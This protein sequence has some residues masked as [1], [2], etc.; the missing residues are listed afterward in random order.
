M[1]NEREKWDRVVKKLN[2]DTKAGKVSWSID[3]AHSIK[4]QDLDGLVFVT[5]VMD[6]QVAVYRTKYRDWLDDEEFVWATEVEIVFVDDLG[7]ILWMFP[8]TP[9]RW[10]LIETVQSDFAGA[11]EFANA[12]LNAA[13]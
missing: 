2:E 11:D 7:H 9:A 5:R 13:D 12:F 8:K 6:R 1:P 4:P 10:E 3:S